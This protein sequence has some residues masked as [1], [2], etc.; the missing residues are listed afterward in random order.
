[1]GADPPPDELKPAGTGRCPPTSWVGTTPG[2][3]SPSVSDRD[4]LPILTEVTGWLWSFLVESHP[5]LGRKGD[6]CP[7]MAQSLRLGRTAVSTV[8]ISGPSGPRHLEIL[9]RSA[10]ARLGDDCTGDELYNSFVMVPIGS[11]SA[12]RQDVVRAVQR[13]LKPEAV[14][15]GK[16][17]GDFFPG[18]PMAA[19]HNP[20]FRPM[21]SPHPLLAVRAM[22]VTDI[23]FLGSPAVPAR[24]RLSSLRVWHNR[25]GATAAPA[26]AA[27]YHQVRDTAE[28]EA[29]AQP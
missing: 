19:I 4:P 10:L 8:D 3:G 13:V 11:P 26:W 6:V 7:F 17:I 25:F 24:D 28:E 9:A 18:N 2:G 1:M 27:L 22:V 5:R 15:A 23:L 29:H 20:L 12:V 14:A 21:A 16:M